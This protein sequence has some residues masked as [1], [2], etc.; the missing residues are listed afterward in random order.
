LSLREVA[1]MAGVTIGRIA[2]IQREIEL[3][4]A[5]QILGKIV[6]KL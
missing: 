5:D 1:A 3:L 6:S 4:S 2:E